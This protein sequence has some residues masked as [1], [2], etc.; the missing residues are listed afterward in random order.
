MR[1][2]LIYKRTHTGDPDHK[3]WQMPAKILGSMLTIPL[4]QKSRISHQTKPRSVCG[5]SV[6][7]FGAEWWAR[8]SGPT[9]RTL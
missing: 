7:K 6:Q 2:T 5:F 8:S 9:M 4:V 1:L 3:T